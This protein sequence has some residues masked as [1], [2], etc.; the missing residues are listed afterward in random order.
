MFMPINS[1]VNI[2]CLSKALDGDLAFINTVHS[3]FNQLV[4]VLSD[5]NF[6]A[7]SR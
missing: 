7:L 3:V 4:R 5:K 2:D 6:I 1:A